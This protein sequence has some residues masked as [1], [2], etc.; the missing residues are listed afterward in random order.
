LESKVDNFYMNDGSNVKISNAL[1]VVLLE[2][3][4]KW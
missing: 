3:G 1:G 2:L 4:N